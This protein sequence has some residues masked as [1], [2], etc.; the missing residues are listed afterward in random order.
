MK[1]KLLISERNNCALA[2]NDSK[3]RK[4]CLKSGI[5]VIRGLKILINLVEKKIITKKRAFS[6]AKKISEN[7]VEI[8]ADILKEFEKL[9]KRIS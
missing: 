7:N 3:L 9:L 6:V 4:E 8:T 2:T 5:E 1:G